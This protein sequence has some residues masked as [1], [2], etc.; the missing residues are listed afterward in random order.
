MNNSDLHYQQHTSSDV[1]LTESVASF[2][3]SEPEAGSERGLEDEPAPAPEPEA[4]IPIDVLSGHIPVFVH[5][6]C[7]D[8]TVQKH[9]LLVNRKIRACKYWNYPPKSE[10]LRQQ[11]ADAEDDEAKEEIEEQLSKKR[12][13]ALA[14]EVEAAEMLKN[15]RRYQD[16]IKDLNEES[17]EELDEHIEDHKE[18]LEAELQ[19]IVDKPSTIFKELADMWQQEFEYWEGLK[20]DADTGLAATSPYK[21]ERVYAYPA[22]FKKAAVQ[23]QLFNL[24]LGSRL[25]KIA[26]H[27]RKLKDDQGAPEER[28]WLTTFFMDGHDKGTLREWAK[29]L[30]EDIAVWKGRSSV[31]RCRFDRKL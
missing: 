26:A 29:K 10:P 12:E 6:T 24:R 2:S 18:H 9:K 28:E 16:D 4:K 1:D 23:A 19:A 21:F 3:E 25:A 31:T 30:K 15:W 20:E 11:L 8:M 7:V 27:A 5:H 14:E 22:A 13:D 17:Q